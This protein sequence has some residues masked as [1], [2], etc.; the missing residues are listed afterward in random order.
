MSSGRR[1][2]VVGGGIAGM[3]AAWLLSGR[4]EVTLY[5]KN[6]RIGGH[7]N[8]VDAIWP[9][10]AAT[11]VDTGFIVY[12]EATYPNLTALF[13]HLEVPT[14]TA[15][16]DFAVSLDNGAFEYG[17]AR[18]A[19][20]FAQKRNLLSPR[21]WGMLRDLL[22]FYRDAP[23]DASLH[24]EAIIS[25]G[26]Y[27]QAGGYC[28]AFLHDHLYPQAAAI[29]SASVGSIRDY[30]AQSLIRFF[31][32]HGLLQ[33]VG[34]PQWRTVDGGAREYVQR[35]T[36]PYQDRIRLDCG[37]RRIHRGPDQVTIEDRQGGRACFDEVLIAA[38]AD[39]A[40]AMLE[41][42]SAEEQRLLGAFRYTPN[43]AVL[44]TDTAL[45]PRRRAAWSSWNYVGDRGDD[46]GR[47]VTYWM[48]RLQGLKSPEPLFVTLNPHLE[49]DPAKVMRRFDYEHPMFDATAMAAQ[50]ELW[51]LQGRQR[52]WFCGAYFGAGFH[53][54][55]L[56]SGLAAAEALGGVRRPW[57]VLKE[58]GRIFLPAPAVVEEGLAA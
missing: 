8:T 31:K 51:A 39:E 26:E 2:A 34:R 46:A 36:A 1:I 35:L 33:V 12:N 5:D 22:R 14:K 42:P 4:H 58:S 49:P 15:E 45:M 55:G 50:R 32:N 40:L 9:D 29:W 7:S 38:H 20:I 37:V 56:Q 47:C 24:D 28:Q 16:M 10:G 3:S 30:P 25:I 27:L 53:E 44:H 54:D 13:A 43:T 52:T 17:S 21:F 23:A 11:P 18:P 19:A 57:S 41:A 6:P 48:N